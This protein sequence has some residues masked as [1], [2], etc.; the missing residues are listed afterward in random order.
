MTH[1]SR[2]GLSRMANRFDDAV[3]GERPSSERRPR[4][5]GGKAMIA[6]NLFELAVNADNLAR[7][8]MAF[9]ATQRYCETL[10]NHLHAT[11]DAQDGKSASLCSIE[12]CPF[13]G[14]AF[15][16]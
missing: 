16:G 7:C 1:D 11:A 2:Y 13:D 14:I 15:R 8:H 5:E 12:H 6:V 9:H 10:L 4:V 3:G